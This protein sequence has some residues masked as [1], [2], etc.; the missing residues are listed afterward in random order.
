MQSPYGVNQYRRQEIQGATPIRLVIMAY[1][2]AIRACDRSDFD[3]AYKTINALRDA[4]D[5]NY[6][7]VS[8]HLLGLYNWCLDNI[9][10]GDYQEAKKTLVDLRS[11][12]Y[13]VEKRMNASSTEI[14][15]ADLVAN[16]TAM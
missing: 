3:S 8:G 2:M 10:K 12:W 13:A 1:D 9:R 7:E 11:A 15:Q 6:A 16:V 5:L 4:L 14:A